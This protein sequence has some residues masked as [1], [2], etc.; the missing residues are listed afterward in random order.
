MDS[1]I[2]QLIA[3]WIFSEDEMTS[4]EPFLELLAV[5]N[6]IWMK[7][8]LTSYDAMHSAIKSGKVCGV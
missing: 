8:T 7:E 5:K 6:T 1:V 4:L 3:I 2:K